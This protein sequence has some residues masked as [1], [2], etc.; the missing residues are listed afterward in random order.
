[1]NILLNL[2]DR[3][4]IKYKIHTTIIITMYIFTAP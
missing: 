2:N 3:N 4:N 1:M